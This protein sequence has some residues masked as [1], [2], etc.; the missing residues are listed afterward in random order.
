MSG[1]GLVMDI[2]KG[3][4]AVQQRGMDVTAHN[5]AN[6][7]TPGYSRQKLLI[8]NVEAQPFGGV[9]LG[10]GVDVTTVERL[11]NASVE[12]RL[13]QQRSSLSAYREMEDYTRV[14][15]GLMTEGAV[16]GVTTMMED[17]WNVWQDVANNP[18][19][20]PEREVLYERSLALSDRF[21]AL[22]QDLQRLESDLTVRVRSH[23]ARVN[24]LTSQIAEM[25]DR[26]V[27]L[28]RTY[29]ANDLRDKRNALL[30]ELA[31]LVDIRGFEQA[32]GAVT[33]VGPKGVVL[34]QG[35]ERY[36]LRMNVDRVEYVSS[37]GDR[38]DITDSVSSG[39]VAGCL[40]VR[41][42][43]LAGLRRSLDALVGEFVFAVNGQ[44]SQGVGL[45]GL[46]AVTGG[47]TVSD[48][49]AALGAEASGLAFHHKIE[50]GGFTLWIYDENGEVVVSGGTNI[51]VDS[52][53]TTLNT[54]A[55][56]IAAAHGNISA[57]V[58]AGKLRITASGSYTFA[59]SQDTSHVLAALG[60]NTFFTGEG[61]GD[62]KVNDAFRADKKSI[63]AGRV[64][65]A[66]GSL[67]TGDN[68]NAL[69][70]AHLKYGILEIPSWSYDRAWGPSE[71]TDRSTLEEY[72][73]CMITSVGIDAA[74][75]GRG[76][77]LA[78]SLFTNL[79]TVRDSISAVSLDEEMTN[80][81]KLQHAYGAA[82]K[83]ISVSEEMLKT[84]LDIK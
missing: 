11:T 39:M 62:V 37:G 58:V 78:E 18:A 32:G 9:L 53:T 23:V 28:E 46:N 13:M 31:E 60:C 77:D 73:H 57:A 70:I 68:T 19:G 29:G 30:G 54:L 45:S 1:L 71:G 40:T 35:N 12:D 56:D 72:Y 38:V 42:E 7:D 79:S 4:L 27:G 8:E 6:V 34:V 24:E 26:I 61:A 76:R 82:A 10:R 50:D 36:A 75:A 16:D 21:N 63:A 47:Y 69:A 33:V 43:S 15:E 48:P 65:A 83:L 14:L 55:A 81:I 51:A 59:F 2:A 17:F 44:H 80:L 20:L 25:N 22:A 41:D 52:D 84:L 64:D 67:A 5:I 3:A 66:T 74:S 49:A